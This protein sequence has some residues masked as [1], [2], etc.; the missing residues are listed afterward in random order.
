MS[1]QLIGGDTSNTSAIVNQVNQNIAQLKVQDVTN[2]FKDDTGTRRVLLGKGK[3]DFYG[4]KVSQAGT[5]VYDGADE[6]MVFNSDNNIFKIVQSGTVSQTLSNTSNTVSGAA[7]DNP[8]EFAIAHNLGYIPAF[9]VYVRAPADFFDGAVLFQLPHSTYINND[10]GSDGLYFTHFYAVVDDTNL[11]IKYDHRSNT[12]YSPSAPTFEVRY[13]L[14][15]ETA[16]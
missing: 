3:D 7:G 11:T 9:L 2:I 12:D 4:L 14:L 8:Q 10:G 13:Y 1:F 15:Q 5:D 6:D 16:N